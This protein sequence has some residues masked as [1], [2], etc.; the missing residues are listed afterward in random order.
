MNDDCGPLAA[1]RRFF[2]GLLDSNVEALNRV[3]TDD[4]C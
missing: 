1:E 3:L 4:F 2:T